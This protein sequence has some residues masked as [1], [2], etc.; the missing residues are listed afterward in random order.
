MAG[1][2]FSYL[3]AFSETLPLF[4][5]LIQR[6]T[7]PILA[8]F[9][10]NTRQPKQ[11]KAD[12]SYKR[13]KRAAQGLTIITE[14]RKPVRKKHGNKTKQEVKQSKRTLHP[15]S[16]SFLSVV[17]IPVVARGTRPGFQL[18]ASGSSKLYQEKTTNKR[19]IKRSLGSSCCVRSD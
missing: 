8:N 2:R 6:L 15:F 17:E 3:T 14:T 4:L 10:L 19:E 1:C 7:E 16:L 11:R 13:L 12:V 18:T 5:F 9:G